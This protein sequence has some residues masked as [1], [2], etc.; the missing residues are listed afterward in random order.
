MALE[1]LA[2]LQGNGQNAVA[3]VVYGN[4][5]FDDALLEL[6]NTLTQNRFHVIAA[7]AMIAERSMIRSIAA[8]R[9]MRTTRKP[10]RISA[11]LSCKKSPGLRKNRA[12]FPYQGIYPI[13]HQARFLPT[14]KQVRTVSNAVPVPNGVR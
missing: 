11:S 4:R 12:S 2:R 9:P 14:Q 10:P 7:A 5:H 13:K 1:R 3:V 6:T 8:G